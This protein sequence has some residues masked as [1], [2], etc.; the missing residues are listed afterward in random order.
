M[1]RLLLLL[2]LLIGEASAVMDANLPETHK[3]II[4][5]R[6]SS[7]LCSGTVVGLYPPTVITARHCV[8]MGSTRFNDNEPIDVIKDSFESSYF[9]TEKA[10]LPGDMAILIYSFRSQQDFKNHMSE[11]DLF[12]V[13]SGSQANWQKVFLCG[14]GSTGREKGQYIGMG[15]QRC[16]SNLLVLDDQRK[17]FAA[18]ANAVLDL[19]PSRKFQDFFPLEKA[20][21]TYSLLQKFLGQYGHGTRYGISALHPTSDA[22]PFGQY[23]EGRRGSLTQEGDSG[24]PVFVRGSKGQKI[25]ISVTSGA[26]SVDNLYVGSFSWRIDHKWSKELLRR[27]HNLGADIKGIKSIL[28]EGWP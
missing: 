20:K 4:P 19:N 10:Q 24:G 27:A 26:L 22:W 11:E 17:N 16:G 8:E 28:S 15:Q 9:S 25:L 12:E 13:S 18:E 1:K 6:S 7:G 3:A 23:D 14:F 21:Y 2:S 5:L